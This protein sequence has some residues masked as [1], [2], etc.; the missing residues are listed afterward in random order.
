LFSNAK[1]VAAN[2]VAQHGKDKVLKELVNDARPVLRGCGCS[3]EHGRDIVPP[4]TET[5]GNREHQ[6]RPNLKRLQSTRPGFSRRSNHLHFALTVA[7]PIEG[8]DDS[9]V[10]HAGRSGGGVANPLGVQLDMRLTRR[11]RTRIL[12]VVALV[13]VG[14]FSTFVL[15]REYLQPIP[16]GL[17]GRWENKDQ[18]FDAAPGEVNLMISP[19]GLAKI[20][21]DHEKYTWWGTDEVKLRARGSSLTIRFL[22]DGEPIEW[23]FELASKQLKLV[24]PNDP[25]DVM[26]F[27]RCK[28]E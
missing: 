1:K 27:R 23:D 10:A 19:A 25:N 20:E 21:Y 7:P 2:L 28:N 3:I 24:N 15:L 9:N 17:I 22:P 11:R 13:C 14:S 12:L 4:P 6:P 26:V 16:R 5:G 8:T 18:L